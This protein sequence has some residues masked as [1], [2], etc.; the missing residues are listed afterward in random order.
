MLSV[1]SK[2]LQQ[3]GIQSL[4]GAQMGDIIPTPVLVLMLMLMLMLAPPPSLSFLL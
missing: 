1:Y 3:T 4:Q 2:K